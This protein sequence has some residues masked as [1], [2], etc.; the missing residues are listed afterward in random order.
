MV[1]NNKL[2]CSVL[3]ITTHL[4]VCDVRGENARGESR[5]DRARACM[6]R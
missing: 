5:G 1:R 2:A 4:L 3:T 6:K